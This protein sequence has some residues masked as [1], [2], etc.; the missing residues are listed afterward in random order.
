MEECQRGRMGRT[1]NA[2]CPKGYRRFESFLLRKIP[3]RPCGGTEFSGWGSNR[4]VPR[5][6]RIWKPKVS[7]WGPGYCEWFGEAWGYPAQAE[8]QIPLPPPHR[9][10]SSVVER[11]VC[12]EEGGVRFSL[13]PRISKSTKSALFEF[14]RIEQP[15]PVLEGSRKP[16]GVRDGGRGA[17]KMFE[18]STRGLVLPR[19][20]I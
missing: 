11:L 19:S 16:E 3:N 10:Y 5:S 18:P 13:G 6:G 20:T 12:N 1:R 2:V 8:A 17:A 15:H 4:A 7:D 14:P 9:A